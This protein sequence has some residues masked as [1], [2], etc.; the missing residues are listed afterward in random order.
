MIH[1]KIKPFVHYLHAIIFFCIKMLN[2]GNFYHKCYKK[3]FTK[4]SYRPDNYS[5]R[6]SMQITT[7]NDTSYDVK[8]IIIDMI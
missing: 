8:K 4:W 7:G 5:I 1:T 2:Y 6:F 3:F